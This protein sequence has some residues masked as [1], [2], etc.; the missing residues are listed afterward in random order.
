MLHF[1]ET[2]EV[3]VDENETIWIAE[4]LEAAKF[5]EENPNIDL[6]PYYKTSSYRTF[7]VT[8]RK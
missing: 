3:G 1:F 8:E 4:I 6:T 7:K 2:G 5:A